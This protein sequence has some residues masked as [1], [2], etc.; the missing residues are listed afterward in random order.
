MGCGDES[1]TGESGTGCRVMRSSWVRFDSEAS[2]SAAT[3]RMRNRVEGSS[4]VLSNVLEGN[5]HCVPHRL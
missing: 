2:G 5:P 4:A 3:P 1:V